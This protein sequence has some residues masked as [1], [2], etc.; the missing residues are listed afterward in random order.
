MNKLKK[1]SQNFRVSLN[2]KISVSPSPLDIEKS[3]EKSLGK[4]IWLLNLLTSDVGPLHKINLRPI[5]LQSLYKFVEI[6]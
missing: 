4:S 2:Y 6:G 5:L 1:K 3:I